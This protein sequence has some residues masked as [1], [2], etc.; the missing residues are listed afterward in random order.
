VV[1]DVSAL[2]Q[3]FMNLLANASYA[4]SHH[5]AEGGRIVVRTERQGD[6]V[7]VRVSDNGPGIPLD[8]L[9]SLFSSF[10]TTKPTGEGTGLGLSITSALVRDHGGKVEAWNGPDGGAVFTLQ[11]PVPLQLPG[12]APEAPSPAG[13]AARRCRILIID[14]EPL[15]R[16]VLEQMLALMGHTVTVAQTA[17]EGL[18]ACGGGSFDL[19]ISDVHMPDMTGPRLRE[20][21]RGRGADIPFLFVTGDTSTIEGAS[22]DYLLKPFKPP[23]LQA[24]VE[25]C[26]QRWEAAR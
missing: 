6:R 2:Q 22:E 26:L 23:T 18:E 21:A 17:A 4:V 25:G 12:P 7:T 19:V 15:V 3:V 16:I 24:A 9:P 1:G 5:R 13:A 20:E 11:F 8:I 10:V 14:D